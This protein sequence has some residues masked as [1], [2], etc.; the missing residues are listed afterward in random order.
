[1]SGSD[2]LSEKHTVKKCEAKK[3]RPNHFRQKIQAK[4]LKEVMAFKM[5]V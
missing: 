4:P 1:M 2:L 3:G 5:F